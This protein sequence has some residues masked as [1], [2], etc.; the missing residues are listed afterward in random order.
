MAVHN[1][2]EMEKVFNSMETQL[3]SL[4]RLMDEVN[5]TQDIKAA[6][7]LQNRI[8]VEQ[9]KNRQQSNQA[10]MSR[11]VCINDNK[12]SNSASMLP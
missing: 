2:K 3:K 4:S 6:T 1:M 9:A 5:N 10:E 8:S 11:S 12:K 7:D